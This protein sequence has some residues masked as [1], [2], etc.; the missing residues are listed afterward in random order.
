MPYSRNE[1]DLRLVDMHDQAKS[2][3]N[4]GGVYNVL[5]SGGSP[6]EQ[7]IYANNNTSTAG[8]NP[9]TIS[10]GQIRFFVDASVTSVDI[11]IYTANGDARYIRDVRPSAQASGGGSTIHRIQIDQHRL[12]Q[13]LV[14]PLAFNNNSE[15]TIGFT[16]VG[17]VYILDADLFV[18]TVDAT[19]TVDVGLDGTTTN[20]P[21]GLI[22]AA[23]VATAGL[24]DLGPIVTVGSNE[25]YFSSCTLGALIADFTAG[26]DLAT[27]VG[28]FRRIKAFIAEAETDANFTTTGS[29]GSDAF[30]G[31]AIIHMFK[32]PT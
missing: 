11:V 32:L 18:V 22:A 26:T 7:T 5:Q 13:K 25:S 14:L 8:S 20:D 15:T 30:Y 12:E 24:V 9:G 2:Q 31:F 3:R 27:D 1:Y 17:P 23:S 10:G 6:Q 19:E 28:T 16:A 29:A 21:N 4:L